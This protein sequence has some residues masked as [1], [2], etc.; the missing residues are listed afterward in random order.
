MNE[1]FFEL[2]RLS[3]GTQDKFSRI[4][5]ESE[6]IKLYKMAVK[7]SMVGIC[8]AGVQRLCRW[9]DGYFCG[10]PRK[11]YYKWFDKTLS[12]QHRNEQMNKYTL[13]VL[14]Y[15]RDKGLPSQV[16]KGQGVARLYG[17]LADLRQPGDIDVWVAGGRKKI[18]ELAKEEFGKLTGVNYYH[19][20]YP[21]ISD[22][23]IEAHI[24]PTYLSDPFRNARFHKFVL[25]HE[26]T[27]GC[28]VAPDYVFNSVFLLIHTFRHFTGHGVGGR[29]MMD[30][31]FFLRNGLENM[32]DIEQTT[33]RL[34][35]AR[36]I[37]RLGMKRFAE[38]MMWVMKEVFGLEDEC[39]LC[40]PD[41]KEGRFLL[42]EVM[43][44]GNMGRGET[45]IQ[46]HNGNALCRFLST[47]HKNMHLITHY[48]SE[49]FWS[50]IFNIVRYCWQLTVIKY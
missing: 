4:P 14:A 45:R 16:L 29:H 41:E 27:Q 31:Y 28:E 40:E 36:W 39:L 32:S 17:S 20:N 3:L 46:W 42:N 23:E 44:T 33:I 5:T 48:P 1:L 43:C 49:V 25:Q 2:I 15:F 26:P 22:T 35:A 11:L 21:L 8:F 24:W 37:E 13:D 47:Q 19:I 10:M 6:W 12:I 34:E 30:Y 18:Y 38:A 9:D 7:Q 50:P